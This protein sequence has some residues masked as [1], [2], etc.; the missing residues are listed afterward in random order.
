MHAE[1]SAA[2][3]PHHTPNHQLSMGLCCPLR[4]VLQQD[5]ITPHL[6][7]PTCDGAPLH[8]EVSAVTRPLCLSPAKHPFI[9]TYQACCV[10]P[11]SDSYVSACVSSSSW[12]TEQ[13][14][15]LPRSC[16]HGDIQVAR[17]SDLGLQTHKQRL[18]TAQIISNKQISQVAEALE[19]AG[20]SQ[21]T[22]LRR[23]ATSRDAGSEARIACGPC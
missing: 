5:P 23:E 14:P 6:K 10:S 19:A 11:A 17:F 4:S 2:T 16:Q 7:R 3:G 15:R 1:V 12:F 20:P 13:G 18:C 9:H 8:A 21:C 22:E